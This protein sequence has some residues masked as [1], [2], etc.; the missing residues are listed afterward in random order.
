MREPKASVPR[1]PRSSVERTV[2]IRPS[3]RHIAE[4]DQLGPAIR[5]DHEG[6][7]AAIEQLQV[8]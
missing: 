4:L 5:I 2:D 7:V 3:E 8:W 1:R 6:R